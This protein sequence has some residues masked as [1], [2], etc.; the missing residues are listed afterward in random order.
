[1]N[2]LR[3]NAVTEVRELSVY[4]KGMADARENEKLEAAAK[5][6]EELSRHICAQGYIGCKG[7]IECTS[8]HK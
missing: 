7:G 8:D 3:E 1:M 5:W 2:R 4:L 6:M